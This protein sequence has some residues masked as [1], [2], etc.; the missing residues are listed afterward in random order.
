VEAETDDLADIMSHWEI[1]DY[2]GRV[3]LEGGLSLS[4]EGMIFKGPVHWAEGRVFLMEGFDVTA[5]VT[6]TSRW[7]TVDSALLTWKGGKIRGDGTV[8]LKAGEVDIITAWQ[9]LP[10]GGLADLLGVEGEAGGKIGGHGRVGGD[11]SSPRLT[12]RFQGQQLQYGDLIIEKAAG[13]VAYADGDLQLKDA[14]LQSGGST[15]EFAGLLQ[16]DRAIAGTLESSAF[17][18]RD[19]I[20]TTAVSAAGLVEGRLDGTINRPLMRGRFRADLLNY[21]AWSLKGGEGT[22]EYRDGSFNLRGHLAERVNGFH[23]TVVPAGDW[24]FEILLTLERFSPELAKEGFASLPAKMRN[25]MEGLSFLAVGTFGARGRLRDVNS[26]SAD[27]D[28]ET[29][30]IYTKGQ[31]LQN[32][33]PLHFSWKEEELALEPFTL[34]GEDYRLSISG[35]GGVNSGWDLILDG[36]VNLSM[37]QR[38]WDELESVDAPGNVVLRISGPWENPDAGGKIIFRGGSVK[39]RSLP[40]PI[41]DLQGEG[42]LAERAFSLSDFS[43]VMGRG[44]FIAGGTYDFDSRR[45]DALVEGNLDLALFQGR[46]PIAREMKGPLQA[47]LSLSGPV[48]D[49]SIFGEARLEG[50]E[51]LLRSMPERITELTGTVVMEEGRMELQDLSGSMGSGEV[52]LSGVLDW[53]KD[54]AVVDFTFTGRRLTMV[55]EETAK[56]LLDSDLTL[57]GDFDNMKLSGEVTLLKVRYFR[58]FKDK[59]KGFPLLAGAAKGDGKAKGGP[60]FGNLELD[61]AVSA[62]DRLWIINSMAELENSVDIHFGGTVTDPRLEGEI[63]LLRGTVTYFNRTFTLF[64]GRIFNVPPG[65]HPILEAQAEVT[66]ND[67]AIHLLLE[68]PLGKPALQLTSV[69]PLSQEDLFTLLTV[70]FTREDLEEEESEALAIGAALVFTTPIIEEVG[71][72]ARGVAGVEVFQVEPTLGDEK[73]GAKVTLGT[74]LSDRLFMSASQNVGVTEDQQVQLE[75]QLFDYISVLG[76]QLQRG[77]YRL[78]LVIQLDFN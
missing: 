4:R 23:I 46:I 37:F 55:V 67:V 60:D 16:K 74:K 42:E 54:P 2:D 9:D 40:D 8:D 33:T 68:G 20:P 14:S 77:I 12:G 27:L 53:R 58:E 70:G 25:A 45:V 5:D 73:G 38:F 64:S 59:F 10:A 71:E 24:P 41:V 75:Y 50:A 35:R 66:V 49:P 63:R 21:E 30:W 52:T 43:G 26:I 69:P 3:S 44:A 28:L 1:P 56:A 78:D 51:V 48:D 19:F 15:I 65:I 6:A 29:V 22:F 7:V 76:E 36:E 32:L 47:R 18:L 62:A 39:L 57:S 61:V 11:W 13:N 34:A 72:R 17:N 31:T